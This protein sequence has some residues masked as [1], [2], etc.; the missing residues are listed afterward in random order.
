S[1]DEVMQVAKDL[2]QHR[3]PCDVIHLDTGWFA[4]NWVCDL[5]FSKDRF[6]DPKGMMEQLRRMGFRV[7]LWQ[8]PYVR[9][10]SSI[11]Q[12][13]IERDVFVRNIDGKLTP[14]SERGVI[15]Y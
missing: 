2:R 1:Q 9:Q 3:L 10:A 8:Q 4:T 12:E 11:F 5:E 13:G 14:H 7:S 15:D 6:P